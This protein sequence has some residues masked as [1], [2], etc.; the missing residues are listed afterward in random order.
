[1]QEGTARY[2][3]IGGRIRMKS[4]QL[5][6]KWTPN[7]TN[8]G[9]TEQRVYGRLAIVYDRRPNGVMPTV[10]EVFQVYD[11]SGGNAP[12][13]WSPT[14]PNNTDRF[15]IVRDCKYYFPTNLISTTNQLAVY[16]VN[17]TFVEG[18][19]CNLY[20]KLNGLETQ[21]LSTASPVAIANIGTGAL[22]FIVHGSNVA[23]VDSCA[24]IEFSWRLRYYDS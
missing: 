15:L 17:N 21:F 20:K 6:A 19:E 9:V 3:R 11:Q 23:A 22:Y 7:Q 16:M 2:N 4:I 12:N 1:M 14:N 13:V 18:S 5:F 24:S 8:V 10:T